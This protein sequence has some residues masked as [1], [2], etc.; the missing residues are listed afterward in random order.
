M[1]KLVFSLLS[2]L[3]SAAMLTSAVAEES[4]FTSEMVE[5]SL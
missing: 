5:R 1:S 2:L 3:L 4:V